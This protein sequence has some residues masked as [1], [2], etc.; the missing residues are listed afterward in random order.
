MDSNNTNNNQQDNK[1][2]NIK[3]FLLI[4]FLFDLV[5]AIIFLLFLGIQRC[6]G[7]SSHNSSNPSINYDVE[8]L[9]NKFKIIVNSYRLGPGGMSADNIIE[10]EAVTYTDNYNSGSFSL[11]ISVLSE[12]GRVYLYTANNVSYP[13]DKSKFDN[14]ISYLLLEDT[15]NIFD[16]E[17]ASFELETFNKTE[18]VISTDKVCK[19]IISSNISGTTT[20]LDGFYFENNNYYVYQN[21]EVTNDNPF[22]ETATTVIEPSNPLYP[23]Y[24]SLNK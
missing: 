19:Y 20:Y 9:G 14:L 10:V 5:V 15:P 4:F 18:E 8:K 16:N 11:S 6:S 3:K 24:Q 17:V 21:K 23:Y 1:K 13:E 12:T 22:G 2:K 7:P